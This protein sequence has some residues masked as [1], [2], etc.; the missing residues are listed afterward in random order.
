[1]VVWKPREESQW[2]I[3]EYI[4]LGIQYR[5][6]N[7]FRAMIRKKGVNTQKT[8]DTLAEAR[9]WRAITLGDVLGEK[10]VDTSLADNTTLAEACQWALDRMGKPPYPMNNDKNLVSKWR[11]WRESKFAKWPLKKINSRELKRWRRAILLADVG[12]DEIDR[13][14][15]E[16]EVSTMEGGAKPPSTQTVIHRLNALSRL[17]Q[18][19]RDE[20]DLDEIDLPNPVV[21]GVRPELK[22]AK[23]RRLKPGGKDKKS[24]LDRL[25]EVAPVIRPWLKQAIVLAHETCARQT[26]LATLS[27]DNVFLEAEDPHMLLIDTKNTLDRTVPLSDAAIEAFLQLRE[28]AD[29]H[30]ANP[31]SERSLR[32]N[33][34]LPV[35]S[36]RGIIHAWA[37]LI[38][39]INGAPGAVQIDDL[40]WHC[41]RHEAIS[42]LFEKTKMTDTQ[43][44]AISGHLGRDQ[45]ERYTHLRGQTLRGMLPTA[46]DM[47]ATDG[48][49]AVRLRHGAPPQIK[50]DKG[51]W[52]SLG[53]ADKISR[54]VARELLR[55]AL[56]TFGDS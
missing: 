20:F 56:A 15:A 14:D 46:N 4:E 33:K 18:D 32:W 5:G 3:D 19:W 10:F 42:R 36:G 25:L 6:K 24:E 16:R 2:K 9:N 50:N 26:E 53:E 8:F 54:M 27:W 12:D 11:W 1:M 51:R 37:D 45:L 52:V 17:V 23:R 44:M 40:T 38:D 55:D 49:G 43:I 39:H 28:M 34:P 7:R 21:K 48:A 41:L 31:K 30:N 13:L 47:T 22:Y 35:E 29:E